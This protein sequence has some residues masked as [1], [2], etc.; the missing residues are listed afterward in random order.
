MGPYAHG[1]NHNAL[2]AS[3]SK[4][5]ENAWILLAFCLHLSCR[6]LF[7]APHISVPARKVLEFPN[8]LAQ[9][10]TAVSSFFFAIGKMAEKKITGWHLIGETTNKTLNIGPPS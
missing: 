1:N 6:N 8:Q 10:R 4:T 3:R 7:R 5:F 9:R 2:D